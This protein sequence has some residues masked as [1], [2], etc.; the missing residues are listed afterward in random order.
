MSKKPESRLQLQIQRAIRAKYPHAYVRKIHG[1]EFQAGGMADLLICIKG[2]F[3]M[4][5]VKMPG[6]KASDL[7]QADGREVVA[8]GGTW[9][10]ADSVEGA[11]QTLGEFLRVV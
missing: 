11:L 9:F 7:Q 2:H 3:I 10:T 5:E 8:A 4:C 6:E 1:S